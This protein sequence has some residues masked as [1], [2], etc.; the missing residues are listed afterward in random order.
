MRLLEPTA[1]IWMKIDPYYYYQRQKCRSMNLVSENIRCMRIFVGVTVG[2][3]VKWEWGCRRWQFFGNL[4]GYF[5]GIFRDKASSIILRHATPWRPVTDCKMNDLA[6]LF[7]VKIRFWPTLCWSIDASFGATAQIWM[8][9]DPYYHYQRQEC[10]PMN[11][12]SENV[13]F[14]Q[15]F[16]GVP[17][18]GGAKRHWGLSRTAIYVRL[19]PRK[20]QIYGKQ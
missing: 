12:V 13:T 18:G 14:R 19:H 9:I 17:L 16:A 6:R 20:L 11:T 4:S 2:G 15:I 8:K 10:R 5:L 7:A 1:H 3:G